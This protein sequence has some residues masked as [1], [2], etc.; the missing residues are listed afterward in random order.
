MIKVVKNIEDLIAESKV[1]FIQEQ[2]R[3]ALNL[4]EKAIELDSKNADAHQCAGN[5]YM[6][7]KKYDL[8]I[9]E[10]RRQGLFERYKMLVKG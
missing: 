8:A 5:A 6:S 10:R 9:I 3:E 1:C 2:Y 7:L 4:A